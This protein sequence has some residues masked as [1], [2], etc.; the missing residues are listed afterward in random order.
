[1]GR[2]RL[3]IALF[4]VKKFWVLG[5]V[6]HNLLENAKSPTPKRVTLLRSGA[7]SS[8]TQIRISLSLIPVK[9]SRK[10]TCLTFLS[11]FTGW[12]NRVRE[13]TGGSGLG[14]SIAKGL[15][16]AHGGSIEV[17]SELGQGPSLTF[18]LPLE[19]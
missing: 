11:V 7:E 18:S 10:S 1:M 14:L 8:D 16:E 4:I 3:G 15:I 6:L 2:K 13:L 17:Q 9:V 12:I 19:Q 5:K